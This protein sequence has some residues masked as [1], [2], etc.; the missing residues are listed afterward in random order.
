MKM[1]RLMRHIVILLA[2][3]ALGVLAC[4]PARAQGY[5]FSTTINAPG[6]KISSIT[7]DASSKV[8]GEKER[9]GPQDVSYLKRELRK[10]VV[11]RLRAKNLMTDGKG[12]RLALTIVAVTPNRPTLQAMTKRQG[13]DFRSFGLGGAEIAARLIAADGKDL[14]QMHYRWYEQQLHEFSDSK[15]IWFDA[16][17][18]FDKFSRRLTRELLNQPEA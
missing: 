15:T 5:R 11:Q 17:R 13:L 14:G 7:V 2:S 6:V 12:A 18:A 16:R 1:E 9:W 3:L 4:A 10:K 8:T